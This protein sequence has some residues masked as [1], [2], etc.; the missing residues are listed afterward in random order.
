LDNIKEYKIFKHKCN[1]RS[2]DLEEIE[3]NL[4][5]LAGKGWKVVNFFITDHLKGAKFPFIALLER[6]NNRDN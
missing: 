2:N 3:I 5:S 6:D 4:N 1:D